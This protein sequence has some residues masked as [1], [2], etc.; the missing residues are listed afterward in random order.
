MNEGRMALSIM[1]ER[2]IN[3]RCIACDR[4]LVGVQCCD[5]T[6]DE[7]AA[8]CGL[9]PLLN[10]Y[11][12]PPPQPTPADSTTDKLRDW[13]RRI[14]A[15]VPEHPSENLRIN[16]IAQEMED[17]AEYGAKQQGADVF[18]DPFDY[19]LGIAPSQPPDVRGASAVTDAMVEHAAQAYYAN[20]SSI[21]HRDLGAMRA[22]LNVAMGDSRC[23]IKAALAAASKGEGH[24]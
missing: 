20:C 18:P 22:A 13:A 14:C 15:I 12:T 16:R 5:R 24:D 6:C 7:K 11:A 10:A 3:V 2:C 8:A 9:R 17:L 23:K 4:S 1:Q 21:G 19:S